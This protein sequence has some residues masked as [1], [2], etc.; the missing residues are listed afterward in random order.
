M[1]EIINLNV[2][3]DTDIAKGNI[4]RGNLVDELHSFAYCDE[5]GAD[6]EFRVIMRFENSSPKIAGFDTLDKATAFYTD[7]KALLLAGNGGSIDIKAYE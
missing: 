2:S 4:W 5:P 1:F 6:G 3:D 7:L